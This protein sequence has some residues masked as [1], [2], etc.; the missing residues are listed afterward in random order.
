MVLP[1]IQLKTMEV[2]CCLV[3]AIDENGTKMKWWLAGWKSQKFTEK[4]CSEPYRKWAEIKPTAQLSGTCAEL[5][6]LWHS[7]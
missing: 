5:L 1:R 3:K 7:T 2:M 4:W 6:Q